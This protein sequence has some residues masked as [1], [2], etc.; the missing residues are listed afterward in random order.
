MG[1]ISAIPIWLCIPFAGLLLSIAVMPLIKPE[2]MEKHQPLAVAV[3]SILFIIPFTAKYGMFSMAETVLECVVNDYLTYRPVIWLFCV[4]VTLRLRGNLPDT[5]NQHSIVCHG[6][7]AFK[8]D[9]YN[10]IQYASGP[11]FYQDEF[12]E[13]EKE[14]YYDLLYFPDFEHGRMSDTNWRSAASD[15]I[16]AWS[17]IFLEHEIIPYSDL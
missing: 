5:E 7:T 10:G 2:W 15:G 3:W 13:K 11:S 8:C 14:S 17:T 16:Y 1:E 9:R 4:A 12:M 6:N